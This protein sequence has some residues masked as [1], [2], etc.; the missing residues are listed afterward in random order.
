MSS[1]NQATPS[2]Q[3]RHRQPRARSL[4]GRADLPHAIAGLRA[5]RSS[6]RGCARTAAVGT[7]TRVRSRVLLGD[8]CLDVAQAVADEPADL[9]GLRA[10]VTVVFDV[11]VL[12][13]SKR[14]RLHVEEC[15][16]LPSGEELVVGQAGHSPILPHESD[17][18]G[19]CEHPRHDYF[20]M[21]RYWLSGRLRH[22]FETP[23]ESFVRQY[24]VCNLH[25]VALSGGMAYMEAHDG[26][27][28]GDSLPTGLINFQIYSDGGWTFELGH[29]GVIS[30]TVVFRLPVD[31][32][33]DMARLILDGDE[34]RSPLGGSVLNT[35]NRPH[36]F[37]MG[38]FR[39]GDSTWASSAGRASE[40]RWLCCRSANRRT[41]V[42][43]LIRR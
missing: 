28:F 22:I 32:G 43:P 25:G 33:R 5:T 11:E 1:W 12:P 36:L 4:C 35:Q 20:K 6:A 15:S 42:Q 8:P 26:L 10:P 17:F 30:Q 31:I 13:I 23:S 29:D 9:G 18:G 7:G 40:S 38:R 2:T 41:R 24:S 34:M 39:L 3:T 27:L 21:R 37:E 14:A 19:L 16:C